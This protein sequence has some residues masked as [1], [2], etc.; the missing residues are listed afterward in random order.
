MKKVIVFFLLVLAIE[1]KAQNEFQYFKASG[2][3]VKCGCRLRVNSTFI[4]MAGQ[5]GHNN[6]IAAYT[7]TEN[8]DDPETGVIVNINIADLSSSYLNI[9]PSKYTYFEKTYFQKYAN[10]LAAGGITYTH[11][12]YKGLNALEYQFDQM[13]LPTKA[14]IFIKDKKEYLLQVGTRQSLS[15]KFNLL[16]GSFEFYQ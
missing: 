6:I 16:K 13:G 4:E 15:S 11:I 12:N 8:K 9:S 3:K 7:C 1:G 2:F 14:M 5:Q 10:Q